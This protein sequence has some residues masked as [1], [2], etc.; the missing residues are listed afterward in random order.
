MCLLAIMDR[1]MKHDRKSNNSFIKARRLETPRYWIAFRITLNLWFEY[2]DTVILIRY[3]APLIEWQTDFHRQCG[4]GLKITYFLK[5][6]P[7]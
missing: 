6:E 7:F 1:H 4:I 2:V 5:N 3:D